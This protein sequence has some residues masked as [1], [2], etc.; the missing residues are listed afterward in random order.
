MHRDRT[1][2][3]QLHY[4]K[5]ATYVGL[6]AEASTPNISLSSSVQGTGSPPPISLISTFTVEAQVT[7]LANDALTAEREEGRQAEIETLAMAER[8][9][10]I[11]RK[12]R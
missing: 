10:T 6:D 11:N 4:R 1:R 9:K 7:P 3:C 2:N 5:R 8:V 12:N